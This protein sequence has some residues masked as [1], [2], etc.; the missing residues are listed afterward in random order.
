MPGVVGYNHHTAGARNG[1]YSHVGVADWC[2][3][4]LEV[5]PDSAVRARSQLI[6]GQDGEVRQKLLFD[7]FSQPN[8]TVPQ[9]CCAVQ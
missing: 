1:G 4:A 7:S 5:D 8:A 3:P 2:A 9:A 6:G